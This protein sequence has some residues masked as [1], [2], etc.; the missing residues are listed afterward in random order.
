MERLQ[1]VETRFLAG[2]GQR[3]QVPPLR[4]RHAAERIVG[5]IKHWW[6]RS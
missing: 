4:E 5:V 2:N 6:N 3:G 1:E